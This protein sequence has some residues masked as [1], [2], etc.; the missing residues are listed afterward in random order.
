MENFERKILK[1]YMDHIKQIGGRG[2][3]NAYTKIAG[4][5]MT[6]HFTMEKSPFEQFVFSHLTEGKQVLETLYR[7]IESSVRSEF[8]S[9]MYSELSLNIEFESFQLDEN[10]NQFALCFRVELPT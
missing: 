8:I 9:K 4:N 10:L 2:P 3:K 6:I 7:Q 1:I 5:L